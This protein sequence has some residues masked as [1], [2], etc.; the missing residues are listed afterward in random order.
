MDRIEVVLVQRWRT[1][2]VG[3]GSWWIERELGQEPAARLVPAGAGSASC[4][5][6]A[7]RDPARRT[8]GRSPARGRP[9]PFQ[10]R[11]RGHRR[12]RPGT[13]RGRERSPGSRRRRPSGRRPV[14][15]GSVATAPDGSSDP[16]RDPGRSSRCAPRRADPSGSWS[17]RN[18]R[19]LV[20]RVLEDPEQRERVLH[21]RGFEELQPAVLHER[22]VAAEEL[23]L[24]TIGMMRRAEAARP[25]PST[26]PRVRDARAPTGRRSPPRRRRRRR[27]AARGARRRSV[28]SRATCRGVRARARSRRSTSRRIGVV[29][30]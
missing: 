17:T 23:D 27:R 13:H 26:A 9:E 28:R 11:G 6:S 29:D 14:L 25:A 4:S 15:R 2:E 3:R 21:V 5:R 10:L 22:D 24:Q 12:S 20:Q 18:Q 8:S 19:D 7:A 30:R 16:R 1:G